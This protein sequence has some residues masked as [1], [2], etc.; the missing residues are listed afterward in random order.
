MCVLDVLGTAVF[1]STQI[2]GKIVAEFA[3]DMGTNEEGT[4]IGCGWK[5][6][7]PHASLANGTMAYARV[8]D[9]CI[10]SIAAHALALLLALTRKVLT[11]DDIVSWQIH[12][13]LVFSFV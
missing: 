10:G 6:C 2:K 4:I 8:P 5:T 13:D 3:M 7:A 9:Y 1:D 12:W 11:V